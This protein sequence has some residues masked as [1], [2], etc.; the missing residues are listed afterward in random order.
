MIRRLVFFVLMAAAAAWCALRLSMPFALIAWSGLAAALC[1]L[2]AWLLARQP[3][4]R[5]TLSGQ[6]G[7]GFLQWGYTVGKGKL[8]PITV[9]S[10]LIWTVLG[11]AVIGATLHRT[12]PLTPW[13]I[14]AWTIDGVAFLYLVGRMITNTPRSR[15]AMVMPIALVLG[16]IGGSAILWR[17]GTDSARET[18]LLVGGAPIPLLGAGYGLMLGAML[19]GG[20]KARWQ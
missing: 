6:L 8:L 12:E 1:G 5:A 7:G 14:L 16:M 20:R 15:A 19:I 10:W 17:M 3:I 4:G 2:G 11:A 13:M 9:V 18:A